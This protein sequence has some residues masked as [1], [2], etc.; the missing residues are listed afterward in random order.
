MN[1]ALFYS[2]Q[3]LL[4]KPKVQGGG[5]ELLGS[6]G[7]RLPLVDPWTVPQLSNAFL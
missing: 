3:N 2:K 5:K 6:R 7:L 1:G 4:Q